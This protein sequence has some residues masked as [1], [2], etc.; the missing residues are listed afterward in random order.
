LLLGEKLR[1][2]K[3]NQAPYCSALHI[4]GKRRGVTYLL[5]DNQVKFDRLVLTY[6]RQQGTVR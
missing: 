3:Q 2:Y 5:T 4:F 1:R 6:L